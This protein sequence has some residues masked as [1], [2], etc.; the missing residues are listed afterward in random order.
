[1]SNLTN[2]ELEENA[3]DT[4]I[5]EYDK[6][7]EFYDLVQCELFS[8][9]EIWNIKE[10]GRDDDALERVWDTLLDHDWEETVRNPIAVAFELSKQQTA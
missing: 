7:G 9:A 6:L 10:Y 1:M 8:H 2:T 4:F 5:L 3:W